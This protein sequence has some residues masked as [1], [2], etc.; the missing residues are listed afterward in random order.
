MLCFKVSPN[1]S[2]LSRYT[3]KTAAGLLSTQNK[4]W[5]GKYPYSK[6]CPGTQFVIV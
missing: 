2:G 4:Y 6:S 5:D 3:T 1:L